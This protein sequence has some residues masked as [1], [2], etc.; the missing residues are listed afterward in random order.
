M[1]LHPEYIGQRITKREDRTTKRIY[2]V[3]DMY[4]TRSHITG[5]IVNVEYLIE[6]Y[7][8]G[9]RITHTVPTATVALG[10]INQ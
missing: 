8:I 9:Q 3:I 6:T 5:D 10:L 7:F 4:V 1:N 2:T